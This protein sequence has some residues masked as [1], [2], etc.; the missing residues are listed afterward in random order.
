MRTRML[1]AVM[2]LVVGSSL[3]TAH[4]LFIKFDSYFVSPDSEVRIPILNGYFNLSEN[5]G[6]VV[7]R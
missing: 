6:D 1:I 2:T 4:D 7:A 5:W 3:L